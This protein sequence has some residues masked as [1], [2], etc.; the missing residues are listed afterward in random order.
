MNTQNPL[1][2]FA[3]MRVL[4]CTSLLATAP[5]LLSDIASAQNIKSSVACVCCPYSDCKKWIDTPGGKIPSTC[6][7]C[8]RSLTKRPDS[9]K[10]KTDKRLKTSDPF[11]DNI[12]RDVP[13]IPDDPDTQPDSAAISNRFEDMTRQNKTL[14]QQLR[15]KTKAQLDSIKDTLK[16]LMYNLTDGQNNI[17]IRN[18]F[19]ES[20]PNVPV[21]EGD[22]PRL[23]RDQDGREL[24][25]DRYSTNDL[26]PLF[27]GQN[28]HPG[29]LP[30]VNT[31]DTG[32]SSI[33][34]LEGDTPELLRD[35]PDGL[36]DSGYPIDFGFKSL[37]NLS[38]K[39][40]ADRKRTLK[41]AIEQN[42]KQFNTTVST[43][44]DNANEA[45][46]AIDDAKEI[47]T[48]SLLTGVGTFAVMG[49][50]KLW[51]Q[52]VDQVV[53]AKG[54]DAKILEGKN[55]AN[56]RKL[57][58]AAE[59]MDD[60]VTLSDAGDTYTTSQ[61]HDNQATLEKGLMLANDTFGERLFKQKLAN[62][63]F[64]AKWYKKQG[65]L[66]ITIGKLSIDEILLYSKMYVLNNSNKQL[67]RQMETLSKDRQKLADQYKR[68]VDEMNRRKIA[69][70]P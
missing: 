54:L 12:S 63:A 45:E 65:V 55:L 60:T 1:F 67:D 17:A 33:P 23:L 64:G 68:V 11:G 46:K 61:Q 66:T 69:E 19:S 53:N 15:K 39:D 4:L 62:D 30:I 70:A 29:A 36:A 43:Y 47:I 32:N 5:I 59:K 37:E 38:D 22:T 21:L 8:H 50:D 40:L 58:N 51:R 34:E 52:G 57:M 48:D 2:L 49:S 42:G 20:D 16:K 9:Q 41:T 24:P 14:D 31:Y 27:L 7:Y 18:P 28:N 56:Y 6:P 13:T 26:S 35:T 10:K 44:M 3:I 25:D